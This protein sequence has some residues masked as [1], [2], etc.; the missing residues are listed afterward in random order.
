[1]RVDSKRSWCVCRGA[2]R[3]GG[4]ERHHRAWQPGTPGSSGI[5]RK[6]ARKLPHFGS[7]CL[8]AARVPCS[9]G[10]CKPPYELVERATPPAGA[11]VGSSSALFLDVISTSEERCQVASRQPKPVRDVRAL[12]P[13]TAWRVRRSQG[14]VLT[15]RHLIGFDACPKG[16]ALRVGAGAASRSSTPSGPEHA[17]MTTGR[18]WIAVRVF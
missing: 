9:T 16:W 14:G 3:L 1:M 13:G 12:R 15:D 11:A 7:A 8:P 2:V 4:V 6:S 5:C 17:A 18:S 10:G